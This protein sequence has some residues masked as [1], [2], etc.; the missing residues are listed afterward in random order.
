MSV[1]RFRNAFRGRASRLQFWVVVAIVVPAL[2]ALVL[3]FWVYALSIPGAYENGGP[4]PIPTGPLGIA[5][6]IIWFAALAGLVAAFLAA[7][8]RRLHDRGKA[9]WWIMG[10]VA[11]PDLLIAY[12]FSRPVAL[13]GPSVRTLAQLCGFAGFGLSVWALVELGFLRGTSGDNLFGPDPLANSKA[14]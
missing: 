6:M 3:V 10:F 11:A 7:A 13:D 5:G 1:E 8:I 14:N 12:F 2:M 9:W 4:T